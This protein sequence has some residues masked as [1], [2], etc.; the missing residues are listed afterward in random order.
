MQNV[1][2][3]IVIAIQNHA[4]A[5]TDVCTDRERLLHDG[6]T[7][8]A[9]LTGV[10][11]RHSDD[12]DIMQEPIAGKPLQ[13]YPPSG[14]MN[15]LC[16]FAVADHIADLKVL[17]GN[18]VARR[19]QRVCLLSGKIFA[20]PLHFQML[21]G[22]CFAGFLSI[23][24]FL[25][26][27]RKPSLEPPQLLFSF[28]VVPRVVYR[29]SLGVGQKALE[30]NIDTQLFPGWNMLDIAFGRDCELAIVAI[31]PADNANPFDVFHGKSL[32]LLFLVPN[33]S[34]TTN[35][36]AI[37]EGDMTSIIVKLPTRLFVFHKSIGVLKLGIPFL[38]GLFALAILVE[39]GD[40]KI[41]TIGTGLTSLGV[42]S[43]GKGVCF[44]QHSTV[45]LQVVFGDTLAIHPQAYA[46][47]A[48]ELHHAYRFFNG[49]TLFL[50]A[51]DFILVDQHVYLLVF[52]L[53]F[54]ML[55]KSCQYLT[56][57]GTIILLCGFL[58]QFQQMSRNSNGE[59]FH[60]IFHTTILSPIWL[61]VKRVGPL[62]P[63]PKKGRPTVPPLG[64]HPPL[65]RRGR[66][67]GRS[68]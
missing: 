67:S 66:I 54:D 51:I 8:A 30:P 9:F 18:Q 24:R 35:P 55:F 68:L 15:A 65:E 1:E 23:G 29:V 60:I 5:M 13:K 3:S 49:S 2:S 7:L 28:A 63:S 42:E 45:G 46:F 52:L 39:P 37:G 6:A 32:D 16:Q 61:Y 33:Q 14:V 31:S 38:S 57:E 12:G 44:C 27:A 43:A 41:G 21:L 56:I 17:I 22:Q 19:D 20:L 26:F 48:D 4:T 53:L 25:L 59:R 40:G 64:V 50:I 47:V 10:V 36:T 58:H 62:C 11:G 34:E